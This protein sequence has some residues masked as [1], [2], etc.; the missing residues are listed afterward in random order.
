MKLLLMLIVTAFF[1]MPDILSAQVEW[2]RINDGPPA[3][4]LHES[5]V[6][7]NTIWFLSD[8]FILSKTSDGG[9]SYELY[10]P[11]INYRKEFLYY[12][13]NRSMSF[14]NENVGF[15]INGRDILQTIDGGKTW[16][17]TDDANYYSYIYF[18]D[19][20]IG[21][22][23]NSDRCARTTDQGANW[24]I[25]T[26]PDEFDGIMTNFFPLDSNKAWIISRYHYSESIGGKI[27]YTSDGGKTWVE[28][29]TGFITS[30]QSRVYYYQISMLPSGKGVAAGTIY[31]E[32]YLDNKFFIQVT[33]NFGNSWVTNEYYPYYPK[34]VHLLN[35]ST[36]I[37]IAYNTDFSNREVVMYKTTDKGLLWEKKVLNDEYLSVSHFIPDLNTLYLDCNE[38][39]VSYDQGDS[40]EELKTPLGGYLTILAIEKDAGEEGDQIV[41]AGGSYGEFIISEDRG[42][43]WNKK[44][45]Q[46]D[47]LGRFNEVQI[48]EG[49]IYVIMSDYRIFKSTEKGDNWQ[50]IYLPD[51]N[52]SCHG[53]AVNDKSNIFVYSYKKLYFSS[54]GGLSWDSSDLPENIYLRTSATTDSLTYIA[55]G[56]TY[57]PERH[58][59]IYTTH[60]KGETYTVFETQSE[61]VQIEMINKTTGYAVSGEEL[62][63][64][65]NGGDSWNKLFSAGTETD[66]LDAMGFI[67]PDRGI[68]FANGGAYITSNQG[69]NWK[70]YK[71]NYPF[72][73][74]HQMVI[75]SEDVLFTLYKGELWKAE[76][77]CIEEEK[78]EGVDDTPVIESYRLYQNYPNPFNSETEIRFDI[79]EPG[80][81]SLKV[82]DILGELV[83]EI[84]GEPLEEGTYRY[85]FNI[86]N[87]A[88]G[89]YYCSLEINNYRDVIKMVNLK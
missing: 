77:I 25:N 67:D 51:E 27:F 81:V 57:T 47:D 48:S 66:L 39:Y 3:F 9:K 60:D 88:S 16:K 89:I 21:W 75:S 52:I 43:T 37:V 23:V 62:Y 55:A 41:F 49:V 29:N 63:R 83:E 70:N 14:A 26:I 82:Y 24:E 38:Q 31:R 79:K 13:P 7:D 4:M 42:K 40:F 19:D 53:L 34:S 1:M 76:G 72:L 54:D 17:I 32:E 87:L 20:Q 61:M 30:E 84:I 11:F 6:Y 18:C 50:R 15:L 64:T 80:Y 85:S 36:F 44:K 45:I 46:G 35:D 69:G 68:I 10:T 33:S 58:A 22:K 65:T 8:E 2:T 59:I 28:Q 73:G 86:D 12:Y 56:A 5:S 74:V 71:V 78:I